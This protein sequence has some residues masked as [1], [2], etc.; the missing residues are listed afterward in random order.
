M[1]S[2]H[3]DDAKFYV[4]FFLLKVQVKILFLKSST[5]TLSRSSIQEN[6]IEERTVQPF[7]PIC[8]STQPFPTEPLPSTLVPRQEFPLAN[9]KVKEERRE[10]VS[11]MS[12]N[13]TMFDP[14]LSSSVGPMSS[15]DVFYNL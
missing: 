11:K 7:P 10:R 3:V 9:R 13:Q 14:F 12:K 5:E 4:P 2:S 1:L 8:S 15:S 6:N